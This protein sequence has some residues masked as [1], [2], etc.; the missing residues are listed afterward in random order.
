MHIVSTKH[1]AQVVGGVLAIAAL[2]AVGWSLVADPSHDSDSGTTRTASPRAAR[3]AL[4][5]PIERGPEPTLASLRE[6]APTSGQVLHAPGPFDDRFTL[7]DLAFDGTKVT[8]SATITSDVSDILE[9]E[10]LAGFYDVHGRL[11]GTAR[12]AHHHEE[13]HGAGEPVAAAPDERERFT[14]S[15][16]AALRGRAVAAAVGVPVLVNE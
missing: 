14:I 16:P 9:F 13:T 2:F 7:A 10:A 3:T 15:V 12:F 1:I 4:P 6:L 5:G 8:G 11:I